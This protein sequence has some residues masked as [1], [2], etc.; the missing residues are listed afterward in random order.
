MSTLY[1]LYKEHVRGTKEK[2][3]IIDFC[4]HICSLTN[5]VAKS[6][7]FAGKKI[8]IKG[9]SVKH[10]YDKKP[11]EEFH[12]V[13]KNLSK[14][15]RYPDK[16]YE[17]LGSKTGSLLFYKEIDNSTYLCSV[18]KTEEID[19]D[20]TK[21]KMNYVVTCFRMRKSSYLNNYRLLWNWKGDNPSS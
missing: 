9:R 6:G 11:A 8:H 21:D 3:I 15:V 12:F 7:N 2:E 4:V 17:N 5:I 18:E 10:L 13:L 20:N 16:I 14:I 19:P 1:K